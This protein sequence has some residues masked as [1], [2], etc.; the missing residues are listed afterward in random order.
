MTARINLVSLYSYPSGSVV[1]VFTRSCHFRVYYDLSVVEINRLQRAMRRRDDFVFR[2]P[3]IL[4]AVGWVA[5]R[6]HQ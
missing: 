6:R 4:R 3:L 1:A 2:P 5:M